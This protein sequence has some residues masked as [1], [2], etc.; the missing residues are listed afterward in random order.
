MCLLVAKQSASLCVYFRYLNNSLSKCHVLQ[1]SKESRG[2]NT[3][4]LV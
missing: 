3:G 2:T 4:V 1:E